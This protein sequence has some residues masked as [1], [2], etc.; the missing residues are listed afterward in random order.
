MAKSR[1]KSAGPLRGRMKPK[2][3]GKGWSTLRKQRGSEKPVQRPRS[4]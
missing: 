1:R 4:E 2:R 3:L